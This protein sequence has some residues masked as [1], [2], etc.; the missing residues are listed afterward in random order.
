MWQIS[1]LRERCH[2]TNNFSEDV[3]NEVSKLHYF[4]TFKKI[5]RAACTCYTGDIWNRKKSDRWFIAKKQMRSSKISPT[6]EL[7][8][9]I[10]SWSWLKELLLGTRWLSLLV[11]ETIFVTILKPRITHPSKY[12]QVNN[13]RD[14]LCCN[15]ILCSS[16]KGFLFFGSLPFLFWLRLS[17]YGYRV[18]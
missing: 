12:W 13:Y 8:T 10:L 3:T 4:C 5:G 18:R 2:K 14:H 7:E 15:E 9:K 6:T 11:C 1:H 16:S 17:I